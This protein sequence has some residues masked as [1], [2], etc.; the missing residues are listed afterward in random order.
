MANQ[1]DMHYRGAAAICGFLQTI[2]EP[3]PD[4]KQLYAWRASGKLRIGKIGDELIASESTL[5]E[6]IARAAAPTGL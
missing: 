1:S 6:D 5:R 4:E 2:L 3:A